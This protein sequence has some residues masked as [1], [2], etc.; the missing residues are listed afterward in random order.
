[1]LDMKT[2]KFTR[3]MIAL[4][5]IHKNSLT[6]LEDTTIDESRE[7]LKSY[8]KNVSFICASL[9]RLGCAHKT[10]PRLR[11]RRAQT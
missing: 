9:T 3:D 5:W 6:C 2:K 8:Y 10:R 1:I 7:S 4:P 11:K